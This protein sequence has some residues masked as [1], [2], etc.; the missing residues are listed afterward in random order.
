[1]RNAL[2]DDYDVDARVAGFETR[3]R[4]AMYQIYVE[5]QLFTQLYI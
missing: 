3:H 2:P 1:M 5:I 4:K